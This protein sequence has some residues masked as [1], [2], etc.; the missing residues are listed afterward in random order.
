M[1]LTERIKRGR[2]GLADAIGAG[3]YEEFS[4]AN[5]AR[6]RATCAALALHARGRVLDVGCG[7]MPFRSL[8]LEHTGR[9]EGFDVERRV[10]G[11]DHLGDAQAM[12]ALA[13]GAYDTVM[14]LEVLEHLPNPERALAEI[15]RV[16][17]PGGTLVLTVP[18]LSRLHE[19]PHDYFRFTRHG[20][21]VMFERAGLE[22]VAIQHYGGLF[23]FVA[24]QLSTILLGL[25]W[26]LRGVRRLVYAINRLLLVLPPLWLDRMDRNGLFAL[27]YLAVARRPGGPT[28]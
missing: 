26:P 15:A 12:T 6:F 3:L 21:R 10:P 28:G 23:S 4:A 27:G 7:H 11:V 22:P 9:Y 17:K 5:A 20:L 16:L 13:D 18:H 24:H 1:G 19:E 2:A 8:V 25:V 14:C